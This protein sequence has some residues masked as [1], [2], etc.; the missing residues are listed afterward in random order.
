MILND[1]HKYP[2][3]INGDGLPIYIDDVNEENRKSTHYYC[4]GCGKELFPVL[5]TKR[6]HHFRHEKDAICDPNKYLHEFAKAAIKK[7]FDESDT[8][9][10][11]YNVEYECEKYD[12]C[13]FV[14]DY[15]WQE[16]KHRGVYELD[17]KK[18]YDTCVSEKGYYQELPD[19]KRKYIADLMLKDSRNPSKEQVCI[20]VWVTHECT[21]DKKNNGGRI[22][23]VKINIED[24]A[25][26]E[27]KESESIRFYNFKRTIHQEPQR[28]FKHVKLLPGIYGKVI[29]TDESSCSEGLIYDLKGEKEVIIS[30][31]KISPDSTKLFYYTLFKLP[32]FD[33]CNY[34]AMNRLTRTLTCKI[35]RQKCP[36]E[37]FSYN[38]QYG[39]QILKQFNDIPYW[40]QNSEEEEVD[41]EI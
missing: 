32:L 38:T 23:E 40:I 26:K 39:K 6:K 15:N 11:Y 17:L 33:L 27:L 9:V 14:K 24:D 28:V 5:G 22:I 8:F 1:D 21:E 30:S 41:N 19:G 10:V 25:S 20:E 3:A 2:Y 36:C 37:V 4:Y 29:V 35:K 31:T 13:D 34:A 18:H 12:K 16:C 7:R